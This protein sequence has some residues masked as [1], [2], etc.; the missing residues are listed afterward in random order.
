[1]SSSHQR[2]TW[3]FKQPKLDAISPE[4]V[5]AVA[6]TAAQQQRDLLATVG[7]KLRAHARVEAR[8]RRFTELFLQFDKSRTGELSC[9]WWDRL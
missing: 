8:S 6:P 1:M 7:Q 9:A 4:A 2:Y 5:Q 3:R